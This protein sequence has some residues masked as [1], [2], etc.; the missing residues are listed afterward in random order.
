MKAALAVRIVSVWCMLFPSMAASFA[1][2]HRFLQVKI[3]MTA[4]SALTGKKEHTTPNSKQSPRYAN[5]SATGVFI[6]SSFLAAS[7]P[8][9]LE[10]L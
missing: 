8:P 6:V 1:W 3:M 7:V 5:T 4:S 9:D 2:F 10:T